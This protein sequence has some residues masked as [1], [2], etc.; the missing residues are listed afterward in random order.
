MQLQ[1][2]LV[3]R[4]HDVLELVQPALAFFNIEVEVRSE[5]VSATEIAERRHLD[6]FLIDCDDVP[7]A[8]QLLDRIRSSRS[9]KLSSIFAIVNG[10]TTVN[11]ALDQGANFVLGKPLAKDRFYAYLKIARAFMEREHRRY[12]RYKVDV[13]VRVESENQELFEGRAINISEGGILM[14]AP[15]M[16]AVQG[17]VRLT[18][19]IPSIEPQ[20]LEAKGEV[21]WSDDSGKVGVR[22]FYMSENSRQR[23]QQWF[24]VLHAQL[25]FRNPDP[26]QTQLTSEI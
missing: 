24:S 26:S 25:E 16:K 1:C 19:D 10:I 9:N 22:V 12:F 17:T 6:G 3:T 4:Q 14:Y 21:V 7:G 8:T 20:P 11:A 5:V 23:L 13:P 15:T 18:I 2:L